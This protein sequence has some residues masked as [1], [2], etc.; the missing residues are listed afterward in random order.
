MT[1]EQ[2]KE[3][4]ERLEALMNKLW[5]YEVYADRKI[6]KMRKE[7]FKLE[8]EIKDVKSNRS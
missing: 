5:N 6:N 7:I 1:P 8:K 4:R 3:L 2:E